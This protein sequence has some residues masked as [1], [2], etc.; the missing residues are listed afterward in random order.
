MK[1]TLRECKGDCTLADYYLDKLKAAPSVLKYITNGKLVL[2]SK[3]GSTHIKSSKYT[4]VFTGHDG[5]HHTGVVGRGMVCQKLTLCIPVENP[6]QKAGH[7]MCHHL[8]TLHAYVLPACDLSQTAGM[9]HGTRRG[10]VWCHGAERA[11][12]VLWVVGDQCVQA[13]RQM[14]GRGGVV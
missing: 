2:A 13:G 7:H 1:C 9:Q 4:M 10:Q 11:T 3:D 12:M 8:C 5:S 14:S 6:R